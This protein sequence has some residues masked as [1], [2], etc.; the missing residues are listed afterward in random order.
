VIKVVDNSC[1][2]SDLYGP[3]IGFA[4]AH[5]EM[6]GLVPY[7]SKTSETSENQ[8]GILFEPKI[9][10]R[11][12]LMIGDS[13]NR[14]A[15]EP[16]CID[17]YLHHRFQIEGTDFDQLALALAGD[18]QR[19]P[20]NNKNLAEIIS[21]LSQISAEGQGWIKNQAGFRN[22]VGRSYC[23]K[24]LSK[25]CGDL[26]SEIQEYCNALSTVANEN[27]FL[28]IL[29][30]GSRLSNQS[31]A[32]NPRPIRNYQ[33]LLANL[34]AIPG[35][36]CIFDLSLECGNLANA[37]ME[38]IAKKSIEMDRTAVLTSVAYQQEP[39]SMHTQTIW[40]YLVN[41]ILFGRSLKEIRLA[42]LISENAASPKAVPLIPQIRS[43]YS[44][45]L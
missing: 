38:D 31:Q 34:N 27:D 8:P 32:V 9:E 7:P 22:A 36:K 44:V 26:D 35:W 5:P 29:I 18:H 16:G 45:A 23:V 25:V 14:I 1:D 42:P 15:S 33:Q 6:T 4:C 41:T 43:N 13:F 37:H 17:R 21:P 20:F 10:V 12:C 19:S 39:T 11:R 28:M 30:D 40:D 2:L 24:Q 3:D